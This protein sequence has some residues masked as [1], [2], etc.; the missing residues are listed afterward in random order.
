MAKYNQILNFKVSLKLSWIYY[1]RNIDHIVYYLR[2]EN[3]G[4][5]FMPK[6][7]SILYNFAQK[8]ILCYLIE[9]IIWIVIFSMS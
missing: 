4:D 8:E 3:Y 2:A 6:Y 5:Y 7:L 1:S 9:I